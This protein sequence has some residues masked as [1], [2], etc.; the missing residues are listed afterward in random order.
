VKRTKPQPQV[1]LGNGNLQINLNTIITT[2]L[3]AVIIWMITGALTTGKENNKS[4]STIQTTLPF[5]DQKVTDVKQSVSEVKADLKDARAVMITRTELDNKQ[6]RTEAAI[7]E[8]KDEQS[9]VR[10][11]LQKK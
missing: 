11:E 7:K 9:K 4:L 8:V 10:D 1:T 5:I 3:G 6:A 2:V